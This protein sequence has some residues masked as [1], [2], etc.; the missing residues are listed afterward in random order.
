M[1]SITMKLSER[2]KP[3]RRSLRSLRQPNHNPIVG[4]AFKPSFIPPARL[5]TDDGELDRVLQR[6]CW[7]I[8]GRS[9]A[10]A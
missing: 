8:R 4:G 5:V 1:R 6:R 7:A 9:P 3:W 10:A 2:F